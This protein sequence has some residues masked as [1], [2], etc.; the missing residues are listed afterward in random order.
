M[1]WHTNTYK[2]YPDYKIILLIGKGYANI[3]KKFLNVLE[4]DLK[5]FVYERENP[6][7]AGGNEMVSLIHLIFFISFKTA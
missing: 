3:V 7:P 4:K 6:P 1:S 2:K 5:V